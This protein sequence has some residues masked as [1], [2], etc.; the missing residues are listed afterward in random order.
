MGGIRALA[1]SIQM[2]FFR[3]VV[4]RAAPRKLK[5]KGLF[6]VLT[7]TTDKGA[8]Y[9]C[10]L[11]KS[12]MIVHLDTEELFIAIC[13][14]FDGDPNSNHDRVRVENPSLEQADCPTCSDSYKAIVVSCER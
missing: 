11:C 3:T 14:E 10:S 1:Q 6:K 7:L 2:S 5:T 13:P 4:L 9:Y 12:E 8:R